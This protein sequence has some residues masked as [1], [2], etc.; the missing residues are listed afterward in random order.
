MFGM[1]EILSREGGSVNK[2]GVERR[3]KKDNTFAC[4]SRRD[5]ISIFIFSRVL[6]RWY[7]T[8]EGRVVKVRSG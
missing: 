8:L 5:S 7:K 2:V 4:C 6:T 3:G 1:H